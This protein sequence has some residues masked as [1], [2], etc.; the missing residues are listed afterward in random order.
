MANNNWIA[1]AIKHP[2]A[3]RATAKKEGA[4]TPQ[5]TISKKWLKKKAK[6]KG[7]TAARA[8]LAITLAGFHSPAKSAANAIKKF[9]KKLK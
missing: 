5:G 7:K 8:R 4:I 6:G 1:G 3:L 9:R 2:G